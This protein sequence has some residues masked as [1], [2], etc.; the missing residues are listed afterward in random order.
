VIVR[1][2]FGSILKKITIL[3][4]PNLYN[5]IE[6]IQFRLHDWKV[7][8]QKYLVQHLHVVYLFIWDFYGL[9]HIKIY[10][11]TKFTIGRKIFLRDYVENIPAKLGTVDTNLRSMV[12]NDD[13][14]IDCF[15]V[16][17]MLI[18]FESNQI[19]SDQMYLLISLVSLHRA[20]EFS[21]DPTK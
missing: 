3:N 11:L 4:K 19:V 15:R 17:N 6:I 20:N 1:R 10:Q 12:G 8:C 16:I 9:L 5:K 18:L 14:K 13:I 21:F 7:Y 2:D